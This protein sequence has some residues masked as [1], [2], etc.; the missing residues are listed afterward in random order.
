MLFENYRELV[1]EKAAKEYFGIL[2]ETKPNKG[3]QGSKGKA[4]GAGKTLVKTPAKTTAKRSK[5]TSQKSAK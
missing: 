4:K 2:P 1:T 5:K 3:S